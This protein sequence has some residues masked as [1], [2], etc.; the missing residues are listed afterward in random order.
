MTDN[1]SLS[2]EDM[3]DGK[4]Y[5]VTIRGK[6]AVWKDS[7][8]LGKA[9]TLYSDDYDSIL[10]GFQTIRKSGTKIVPVGQ[11]NDGNA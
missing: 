8:L 4:E 9:V 5:E 7:E 11:G 3:E 6:A 1:Q 10:L 2:W